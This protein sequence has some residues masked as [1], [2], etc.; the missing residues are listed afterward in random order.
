MDRRTKLEVG[1]ASDEREGEAA[2]LT[3]DVRR[4]GGRTDARAPTRAEGSVGGRAEFITASCGSA[5][6]DSALSYS[7]GCDGTIAKTN[8]WQ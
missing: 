3:P 6:S 8:G 1:A 7:N 5:A 2:A 4:R